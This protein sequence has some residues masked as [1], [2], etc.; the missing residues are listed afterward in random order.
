MVEEGGRADARPA[1]DR[2]SITVPLTGLFQSRSTCCF[3]SSRP[4]SDMGPPKFR[5]TSAGAPNSAT[6][7]ALQVRCSIG[8]YSKDGPAIVRPSPV[9]IFIS[10]IAC[11]RSPNMAPTAS[12]IW[13]G[14][15]LKACS[16]RYRTRQ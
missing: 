14:S 1:A 8:T 16:S 11:L 4:T 5:P 13:L 15:P 2:E 7:A 10:A 12:C 9:G 6:T 3:S